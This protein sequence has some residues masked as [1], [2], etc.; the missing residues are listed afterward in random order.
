MKSHHFMIRTV[1]FCAAVF[2]SVTSE[3]QSIYALKID[4]K[5]RSEAVEITAKYQPRLVMGADQAMEFQSTV[6]KY[7][8]KR[9]SV[10]ED[11]SLSPKAKYELLKQVASKETSEM[12][13]VLEPFRWQEYMRIKHEIQPLEKPFSENDDFTVINPRYH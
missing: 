10:E 9:K 8:V 11:D 2:I 13:D 1:L 3:A 5:I 4:R 6:A 7:L 12:A